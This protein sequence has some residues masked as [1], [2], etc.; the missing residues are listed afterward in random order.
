MI[1]SLIAL[2]YYLQVP[3]AIDNIFVGGWTFPCDTKLPDFTITING[4]EAVVPGEHIN[5][6][7]VTE[8]SDTCFG[9]IQDNQGL[10]FSILG[11]I[12]LKSQYVVFD[13]EGP[14][15]G[16]APQA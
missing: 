13:S 8:G 3:L 16:F 11:D 15:L 12:F 9:G 1:D 14:R 7:P 6:A 4:Y 2:Q 5:Y 10:P